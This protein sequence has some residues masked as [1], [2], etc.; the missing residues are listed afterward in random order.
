MSLDTVSTLARNKGAGVGVCS[1]A[2]PRRTFSCMC[3]S[4]KVAVA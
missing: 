3:S 1:V 2:L 4:A